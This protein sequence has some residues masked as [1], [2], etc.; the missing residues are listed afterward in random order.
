MVESV[1]HESILAQA[2]ADA[3]GAQLP[4]LDE[5]VAGAGDAAA[6][7]T[8]ERAYRRVM[9]RV[10]AAERAPASM[11]ARA[12]QLLRASRGAGA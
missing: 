8:A 9:R 10:G 7:L 12:L 11:V 3:L 2:P 1:M 4:L 6:C 5:V